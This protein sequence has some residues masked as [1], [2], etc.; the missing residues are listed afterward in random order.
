MLH[1]LLTVGFGLSSLTLAQDCGKPPAGPNMSLKDSFIL[2]DSFPDG[3][4]ASF[5]CNYGYESIAGSRSVTC[6]AGS[7]SDLTYKCDRKPCGSAGSIS[8]GDID[9]SRGNQFG[10][11]AA[12]ICHAGYHLFGTVKEL[13]CEGDGQWSPHLPKCEAVHCEP[14]PRLVNGSF[15]PDREDYRYGDTIQYSCLKDHSLN[16][17]ATA[18][19]SE[20]KTFKP[21]PPLCPLV[22]CRD[23]VVENGEVRGSRPPHRHKASVT[24][25]CN[26]GF[27]LVGSKNLMCEI[28]SKWSAADP[29]CQAKVIPPKKNDTGGVTTAPAPPVTPSEAPSNVP[30]ALGIAFA[31]L[32]VIA[33]V[34]VCGCYYGG[35]PAFIRRKRNTG[36]RKIFSESEAVK[37]EAVALS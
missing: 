4:T 14:P 13:T 7:W 25:S 37:E 5:Q 8:N 2:K 16:G 9:Y 29:I 10:D 31:V 36:S 28:N 11:K 26:P 30:R 27:T 32:T 18:V 1:L 22:S 24:V 19:C 33:V 23:L 17:S 6:T 15:T 21:A 20:D 3:S 34:T 35:V 12:I